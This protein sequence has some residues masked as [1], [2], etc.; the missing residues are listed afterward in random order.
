[1]IPHAA[2][3]SSTYPPAQKPSP[4]DISLFKFDQCEKTF[5]FKQNLGKHMKK[6]HVEL[7]KVPQ[8]PNYE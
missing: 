6:T 1:M 3:S 7:K 5:K 4:E 8:L 2:E